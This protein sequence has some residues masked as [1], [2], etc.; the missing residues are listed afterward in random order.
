M[1][2]GPSSGEETLSAAVSSDD[3]ISANTSTTNVSVAQT[4]KELES[5]SINSGS[6]PQSQAGIG[7]ECNAT[8]SSV[9]QPEKKN[10]TDI[11]M[12]RCLKVPQVAENVEVCSLM[13]PSDLMQLYQQSCSRM[14]MAAK[15][16]VKLFDEQT[17]LTHNVS[18]RGK[19]KLDSAIIE[20]I[21]LQC[22]D[23]FPCKSS[24]NME[25]EWSECVKAID[26]KSRRLKKQKKDSVVASK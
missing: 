20:Y 26:E 11:S 17:R 18:G 12:P 22:F 16:S 2:H 25:K 8:K 1:V 5:N 15:L 13:T 4:D 7:P 14:N 21:K 9:P 23:F 3:D 19:P 6:E 10:A 24:E